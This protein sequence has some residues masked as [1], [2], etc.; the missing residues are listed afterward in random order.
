MV[1]LPPTASNIAAVPSVAYSLQLAFTRSRIKLRDS[2]CLYRI[3]SAVWIADGRGLDWRRPGPGQSG[4]EPI[5]DP[6]HFPRRFISG[7]KYQST[8]VS[9]D[10]E[11]TGAFTAT[12]FC[13]GH[14]PPL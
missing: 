14:S 9:L 3:Y 1:T 7:P 5:V 10:M 12:I 11:N 13:R 8:P 6:H 2:P 4:A